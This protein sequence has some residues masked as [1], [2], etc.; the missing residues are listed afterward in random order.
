MNGLLDSAPTGEGLLA[1]KKPSILESVYGVPLRE[2]YPSE[3]EFF[4]S[5]RDVAGMAAEDNM[6]V[7]NP[8]SK[9]KPQE[10]DSVKMNEA[11]RVFMRKS[12]PPEFSLTE[13]QMNYLSSNPSYA[14]APEVEQKATIAAR[15]L[16]GDPSGG[17]PT[18]EQSAFI[19][20]LR[21]AMGIK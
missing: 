18:K 16:S 17:S 2:P 3:V 1:S 20:S 15:I 6:I 8:F 21:K 7:M 13:E 10:L 5:N 14:Q 4:K 9:L 11:A 12:M 19:K